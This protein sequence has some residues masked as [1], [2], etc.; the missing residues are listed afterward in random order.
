MIR[1][2][3]VKKYFMSILSLRNRCDLLSIVEQAEHND[4][5]RPQ[6]AD[7]GLTQGVTKDDTLIKD[8]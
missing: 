3:R 7:R 8:N 1:V 6:Q 2:R 5:L 4:K